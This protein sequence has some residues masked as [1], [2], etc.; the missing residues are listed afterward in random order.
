MKITLLGCGSSGGTPLL[1]PN[2]WADIDRNDPRNLR[3]R[4]SIIVETENTRILVDTSPD[5]RAQLLDAE[6]WQ[7]DAILFTHAHADHVNGIDDIR[8]LNFH[9][10]GAIDAHASA[11]TID[12]LQERFAYIF[13]P[14]REVNPQ[15]WRPCLNPVVIDG[16]FTI[17]DIEIQ[18]FEQEH[19]RMPSLGFRFGSFGY[20]TD[21]KSLPEEA[22][23]VLD[24]IEV[25][26]VDA[27]GETPH[28][29]HSHVDQTLEWI[30]RVSPKRA[31]LTHL[32][33]RTD[34]AR[35]AAR[36]PAGVEPGIGGMVIQI[37]E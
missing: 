7:V 9:H 27:L 17:G 8:T 20:S 5:M 23:A 16:A 14:Y 29:T 11:Q 4:P 28:P 33:N 6:V 18:P 37:P 10:G 36:L 30:A 32:S 22:F 25:W 3:R 21:V 13:E 19:G 31:V 1:G 2:G 34:Y 15:F 12:I 35:L 26:I 24:G